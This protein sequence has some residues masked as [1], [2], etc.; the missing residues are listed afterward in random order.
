MSFTI[1]TDVFCDCGLWTHGATGCRPERALA[2]KRAKAKGW[3]FKNG[4]HLCPVCNGKA[5][6]QGQDGYYWKTTKDQERYG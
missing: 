4:K 5:I 1:S 3:T 2:L 6:G